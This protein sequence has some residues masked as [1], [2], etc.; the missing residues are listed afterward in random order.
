MGKLQKANKYMVV[1][2]KP[3]STDGV[4][5]QGQDMKFGKTG[6]MIVNDAGKAEEINNALGYDGLGEVMVMPHHGASRD[7]IHKTHFT[8]PEM[9][10]KK[11]EKV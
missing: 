9:P 10:W 7:P 6:A 3:N 5:F 1:K 2:A 4:R 11:K 8:V